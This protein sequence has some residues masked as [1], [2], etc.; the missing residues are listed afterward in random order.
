MRL[1]AARFVVKPVEADEFMAILR[2]VLV[3]YKAGQFTTIPPQFEEETVFYRLYNEALIRKLE[4]KMLD[5][6][7]LNRTLAESEERFRR[8]AENAPDLIYRYELI[9]QKCF[10]Y[11]SPASVAVT[12]YTPEDHY[13]NPDLWFKLAHPDDR[14]LLDSIVRGEFVPGQPVTL[15]WVRKDGQIIWTEQRNVSVLNEAGELIAIEGIARD[16]T[17]RKQAEDQILADQVELKRLLAEANQAHQALLIV[18]EEQKAAEEEIR[19]LNDELELRVRARTAQ[20]LAA[21][22]ELESFSYSVSH[23]LRAPLRAIEGF[24]AALVSGYANQMDEQGQFLLERIRQATGRMGQLIKD[25]LNLSRITRSEFIR[26]QVDLSQHAR[27]IAAE[28]QACEPQRQVVFTIAP[29][30]IVQGD[31]HL[32]HIVLENI[33]SNAWKFSTPRSSALVE[34][35]YIRRADLPESLAQPADSNPQSPVYFVRDNGVGFDMTYAGKLFAPFQRLHG[36]EEFPGTGIGLAIVKRIIALHGG[37]IWA[38]AAVNQG[39][40][41]YFTLE[42]SDE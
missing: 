25:L 6:D 5:L 11:I 21:N 27:E 8:M 4:D 32:L 36:M 26:Q 42:D 41:F 17:Q 14:P 1:G 35:G 19:R 15:R 39:S 2:E 30:M 34:V 40:T 9:P 24:S 12:G 31:A 7:Q 18:L 37:R 28:L 29:E 16:I 23:D 13:N 10:T 22:Q 33:L 20:L 3:E 38:D